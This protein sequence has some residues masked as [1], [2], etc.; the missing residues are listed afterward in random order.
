MNCKAGA[1]PIYAEIINNT[2][3]ACI[4]LRLTMWNVFHVLFRQ[5]LCELPSCKQ[6]RWRK[7]VEQG[8]LDGSMMT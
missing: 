1:Q 6:I 5:M 4:E 7:Q 2:G 8:N 3:N